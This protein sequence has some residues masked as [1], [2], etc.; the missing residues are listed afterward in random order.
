L[1]HAHPN[2][3]DDADPARPTVEALDHVLT[4]PVWQT[5][6]DEQLALVVARQQVLARAE[7]AQAH[8]LAAIDT[9]DA[10]DRAALDRLEAQAR[11]D[12]FLC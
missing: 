4:Q 2:R 12:R 11:K 1:G 7:A 8:L 9:A 10:A 3:H 5:S 6:P